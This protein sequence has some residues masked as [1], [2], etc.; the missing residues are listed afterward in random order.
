MKNAILFFFFLASFSFVQ[1]QSNAYLSNQSFEVAF[2]GQLCTISYDA[3]GAA[4]IS[5]Q[6]QSSENA[7]QLAILAPENDVELEY[8]P[9]TAEGI[10]AIFAGKTEDY[11]VYDVAKNSLS[12]LGARAISS[13]RSRNKAPQ[14]NIARGTIQLKSQTTDLLSMQG[15]TEDECLADGLLVF[16]AATIT[17]E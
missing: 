15:T 12:P 17:M 5:R 6:Q 14:I 7:T 16:K 1:A 2:E 8:D 4:T 3:E 10:S 11:W 9:A 13:I